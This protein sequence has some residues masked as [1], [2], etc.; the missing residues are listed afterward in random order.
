MRERILK[1]KAE[2]AEQKNENAKGAAAAV[3]A[4]TLAPK[5]DPPP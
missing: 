5:E 4:P 2:A 3:L 1:N